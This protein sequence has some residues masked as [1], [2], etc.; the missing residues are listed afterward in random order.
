MINLFKTL[1]ITFHVDYNRVAFSE[2]G[3]LALEQKINF[4]TYDLKRKCLTRG[5]I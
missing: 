1:F 5:A 4:K 2:I 3:C